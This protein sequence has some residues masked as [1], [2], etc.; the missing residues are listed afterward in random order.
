MADVGNTLRRPECAL[1]ELWEEPAS[2]GL[3]GQRGARA[4]IG[5]SIY[6]FF[7]R[8]HFRAIEG[9]VVVFEGAVADLGTN[10]EEMSREV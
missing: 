1:P 5:F 3:T 7:P 9:G 6:C 2:R 10:V 8:P 4:Q